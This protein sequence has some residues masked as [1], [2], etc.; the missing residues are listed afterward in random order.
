ML[1]WIFVEKE[2][3]RL[4]CYNELH[5]Y[6]IWSFHFLR[7]LTVFEIAHP[8]KF[9]IIRTDIFQSEWKSEQI[10]KSNPFMERST[11]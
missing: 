10:V 11:Y 7:A 3:Y 8:T 9:V 6:I 5:F 2:W 4:I 1:A